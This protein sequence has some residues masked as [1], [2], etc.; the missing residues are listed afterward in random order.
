MHSMLYLSSGG[1]DLCTFPFYLNL[2]T[3]IRLVEAF[4]SK[5][6]TSSVCYDQEEIVPSSLGGCYGLFLLSLLL[7]LFETRDVQIY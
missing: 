5:D 1:T 2:A 7:R 6:I 4:S 3:N